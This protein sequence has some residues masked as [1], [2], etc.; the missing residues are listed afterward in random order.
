MCF[1]ENTVLSF[2]YL[3]LY[4]IK[5]LICAIKIYIIINHLYSICLSLCLSS[6]PGVISNPDIIPY[7]NTIQLK[8]SEP[9]LPNGKILSYLIEWKKNQTDVLYNASTSN[10]EY[11][12]SNLE[13]YKG[14]E[15]IITA[16][17]SVGYG[18]KY[19]NITATQIGREFNNQ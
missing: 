12:I 16:E 11:Q 13:A 17:T 10:T 5:F 9:K 8:W 19:T 15:I 7:Y 2:H 14:Y 18:D 6:D 3:I 1:I 4:S